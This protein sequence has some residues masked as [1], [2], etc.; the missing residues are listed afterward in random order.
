MRE[1]VVCGL[2]RGSSDH[3]VR[4]AWNNRFK[5]E[6]NGWL[7]RGSWIWRPGEH[8]RFGKLKTGRFEWE[9][10]LL[11]SS[12]DLGRRRLLAE[13]MEWHP[14][15][16]VRAPNEKRMLCLLKDLFFVPKNN[17]VSEAI[18]SLSHLWESPPLLYHQ[19]LPCLRNSIIKNQSFQNTQS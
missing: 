5:W 3:Q 12:R 1:E 19:S 17:F 2:R 7:Q 16:S 11:S 18:R 14:A 4:P 8:R 13:G 15:S 6:E 9:E 10:N